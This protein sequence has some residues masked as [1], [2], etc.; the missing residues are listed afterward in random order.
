MRFFFN[1]FLSWVLI[2]FVFVVWVYSNCPISFWSRNCPIKPNYSAT[3]YSNNVASWEIEII[4]CHYCTHLYK[5]DLFE[6]NSLHMNFSKSILFPF[7]LQV[8]SC[9]WSIDFFPIWKPTFF[10]DKF[11][12]GEGLCGLQFEFLGDFF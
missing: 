4:L 5:S 7:L 11:K 1:L 3:Y 2:W 12:M 10:L 8:F 9:K 6:C